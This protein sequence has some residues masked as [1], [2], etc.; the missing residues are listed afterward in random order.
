LA[1]ADL[2][3]EEAHRV[4][5]AAL[6]GVQQARAAFRVA[7]VARRPAPARHAPHAP[8]RHGHEPHAARL[9]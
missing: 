3:G 7:V 9:H 5:A 8:P 2:F 4:K 6:A 1:A